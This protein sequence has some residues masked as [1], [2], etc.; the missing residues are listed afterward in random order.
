MTGSW[1]SRAPDGSLQHA[2]VRWRS[3]RAG[4]R[5]EPLGGR[6]RRAPPGAAGV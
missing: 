5:G 1:V 4:S 2:E 3:E 6:H